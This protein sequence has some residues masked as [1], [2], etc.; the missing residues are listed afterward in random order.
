VILFPPSFCRVLIIFEDKE[1]VDF[2][3][4]LIMGGGPSKAKQGKCAFLF[5]IVSNSR[6][7]VDVDKFDYLQRDA[8]NVGIK[9]TYVMFCSFCLWACVTSSSYD[10]GR[11]LQYSRV[12]GDEICFHA[13]ESFNLYELFHTRYSLFKQVHVG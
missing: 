6:N 11:L 8:Y 9:S 3:G 4:D 7:S 13:K 2:I 5:D 10:S 12:F 1:E